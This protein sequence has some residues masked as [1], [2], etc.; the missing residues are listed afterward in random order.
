MEFVLWFGVVLAAVAF[1]GEHLCLVIFLAA[2]GQFILSLASVFLGQ[3]R[4]G[5][6][7]AW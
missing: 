5:R 2:L 3:R 6:H 7:P 4:R 1:A